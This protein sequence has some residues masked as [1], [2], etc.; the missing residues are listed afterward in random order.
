MRIG[1]NCNGAKRKA[2]CEEICMLIMALWRRK[3]QLSMWRQLKAAKTAMAKHVAAMAISVAQLKYSYVAQWRKRNGE[4]G[5][6]R[7]ISASGYGA[8]A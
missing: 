2:A 3:Y 8:M 4:S 7:N 5:V 6:W 1:E